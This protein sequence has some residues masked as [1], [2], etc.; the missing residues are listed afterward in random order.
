MMVSGSPPLPNRKAVVLITALPVW[1]LGNDKGGPALHRTLCALADRGYRVRLVSPHVP[2]GDLQQGIT[3]HEVTMPR[4]DRR[5]VPLAHLVYR[6]A[7]SE[8]FRR[9]ALAVARRASGADNVVLV[10][11]YEVQ[12][13][14]PARD[15]AT[16]YG[17]PLVTRFQGTILAPWL[18][19]FGWQ[20]R[21]WSHRRALSCPADA[22]VMTNDGTQGDR[23]LRHL[24]SW[25]PHVRFWMNGVEAPTDRD[26]RSVAALREELGIAPGDA[27]LL[28]VSRLERWKRVERAV[29]AMPAVLEG[30]PGCHLVIVGDGGA[31]PAL[32]ASA[33]ALGVCE[34]V[35]FVGAV[36]R[37]RLGEYYA[38]ANL[39]LSLYD[40]SN[41]GNPL[42]EAMSFGL[43]VVTLDVGD[44]R[45]VVE[46]GRTGV[47]LPV[48]RLADLPE[49]IVA[50]LRDPS[51]RDELSRAAQ[52]QAAASFWTW[53]QRMA[54]EMELV[55][56]LVEGGSALGSDSQ[57]QQAK[58]W[59]GGS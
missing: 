9:R 19:R 16:R 52:E 22:V 6:A 20:L 2:R 47:V 51:R 4:G 49:T 56:L 26:A 42:L 8:L 48:D 11:G 55:R 10:Y 40:L 59:A 44:T 34:S 37:D 35:H 54:A 32:E 25:G 24:G 21:F 31:R 39:F 17:C 38:L 5:L 41:V 27:V 50:L 46:D 45:T 36:A 12:G 14:P 18:R 28:T 29:S 7:W 53:E 43:C 13:V 58:P 30:I 57:Q 33:R 1:S 3:H 15:L 23:V